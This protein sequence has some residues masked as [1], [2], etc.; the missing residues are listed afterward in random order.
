MYYMLRLLRLAGKCRL[1][2]ISRA[3]S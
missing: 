1:T 2:G 3:F